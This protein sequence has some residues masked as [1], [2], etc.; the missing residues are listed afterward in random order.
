MAWTP[1]PP[2]TRRAS[3]FQF[4]FDYQG[5][6]GEEGGEIYSTLDEARREALH[7]TWGAMVWIWDH[8]AQQFVGY[9]PGGAKEM[10]QWRSL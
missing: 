10:S 8:G 7:R 1:H 9:F 6:G 2:V 4:R 3:G 5:G